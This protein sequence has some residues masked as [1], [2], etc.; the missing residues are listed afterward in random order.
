MA[1]SP[2][3]SSTLFAPMNFRFDE[4][5]ER[6][7]RERVEA[8]EVPSLAPNLGPLVA[9]AGTWTGQG[10]NTIFR[11]DNSKT[12]TPF[13]PPIASDNVLELNLTQE[14]LSFSSSLGSIPTAD[15]GNKAI[16]SSM[17]SRIYK[18]SMMSPL[19]RLSAFI[20]SQAC[21]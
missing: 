4:V 7:K 15:R 20:L 21:G 5:D 2:P 9:F 18:Q 6:I 1:G 12:P 11:H 3:L 16:Y 13:N 14:T 19:R 10:F 17:P 8:I